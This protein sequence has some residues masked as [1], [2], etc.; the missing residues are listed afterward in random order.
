[1]G[2][3]S[4]YFPNTTPK[5]ISPQK[6]RRNTSFQPSQKISTSYNSEPAPKQLYDLIEI[7]KTGVLTEDFIKHGTEKELD[8]LAGSR[9][10][11]KKISNCAPSPLSIA[12]LNDNTKMAMRLLHHLHGEADFSY[13]KLQS[14]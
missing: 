10:N 7:K 12:I 6:E 1:M 2:R 8:S 5:P 3:H 11:F 14:V 4:E 13:S 9:V